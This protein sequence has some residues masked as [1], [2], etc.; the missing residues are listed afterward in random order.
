[1][2]DLELTILG[3]S[4]AIPISNRNPTSQ[5]LTISNRHF[6]IDCGEGTQVK[7]RQ[8]NIGFSRINHI[9]ISHLHGDHFYGLVPLL[10]S[11]HLLDRQKEIHIYGPP[12]LE[13]TVNCI[14]NYTGSKLRFPVI[15]HHTSNTEKKLLYEDKALTVHS[16]PLKHSMPTCG[17]LFEEKERP[18]NI[19]KEKLQEYSI[20]IS[21]I[22]QIK[23]GADWT[24]E[25]G[26]VIPNEELSTEAPKPLSY[27]FCTDTAP[28]P[29]LDQ[30]FSEV[31]LLYHEA[32]FM[33]EHEER[34][35]KTRHSTAKQAAAIARQVKARHLL[36]GHFS[37]R[38]M[39]LD[40]LLNEGR[41]VFEDSH[42]ALEDHTFTLK[43]NSETLHVNV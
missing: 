15:Y 17:F 11:L 27:A 31:D 25:T 10:T 35:K 42:L 5:F 19:R 33:D 24:D 18:R 40:G 3:S 7:L 36:L 41:S 43:R 30:Y 37:V 6:L 9:L 39:N 28:M 23:A 1:M 21:E 34:A 14:L 20:P 26:R 29:H 2:D 22:R 12:I 32:T 8:N 4:S 38:Y 16:F 13:E